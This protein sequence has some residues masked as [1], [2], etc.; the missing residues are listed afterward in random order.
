VGVVGLGWGRGIAA[1]VAVGVAAGP[2]AGIVA[3]VGTVGEVERR[4]FV[5]GCNSQG[6]LFV[7]ERI[8]RV[9]RCL[10]V[11]SVAAMACSL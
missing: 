7:G 9:E 10:I 4:E 8:V 11:G 3:V 1:A 5:V 2:E 6:Q